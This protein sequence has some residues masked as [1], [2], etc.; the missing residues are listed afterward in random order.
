MTP[1]EPVPRSVLPSSMDHAR[2]RR[3]PAGTA[4]PL[5]RSLGITGRGWLLVLGFQLVWVGAAAVS[6]AARRLTDRVDAAVMRS[7][8]SLRTNWLTEI[9]E[10]IDQ[11]G[12]GWLVT[13]VGLGLLVAL[14]VFR[15]WRH[16]FTFLICVVLVELV[17]GDVIYHGFQRPRPYDV[18]I[19]GR[20][21]GFSLPSPP[22]VVV[23]TLA[24]GI[25]YTLVV[26]GR[27]RTIAKVIAGVVV[28]SFAASRVYLGVD[29]PFDAVLAVALV[30]AILVNAFRWFTPN[31]SFPVTYKS[32]KTAHLDVGGARGEA[33][34]RAVSEQM[35][36]TV[37]EVKH[38]GLEGS[39]G[40]TPLRLRIAGDPDFSVFGKLYA[41]SH[42]RADRWYKLGRTILY[43]RLEDEGPFQSV[44]RL[45]E[46]EDYTARVL[47][48][49]GIP[50]AESYGVVELTPEREYLLVTEFFE[51][52]DEIGVADVDDGVIDEALGIVRLLWDAGLA[53]RDIKP[54]NVLVRDGRV[55]LIDVFFVQVR[56]SPW[57]Q[58]VDLANMML[59]LAVRTDARRVYERARQ[60]FT[61]DDIAEAFAAVRGI[62]SPTQLRIA[63]KNDPRDLVGEF[64]SLAPPRRR[65]AL[66]RWSVRRVLL[67]VA[68]AAGAIVGVVA[69][70][71][72]FRPAHDI[73]V[74]AEPF[75]ERSNVMILMAQS[76]PSATALPCVASVPAGWELQGIRIDDEGATIW[77]DS[78]V[79]GDRAVAATL[80]EEGACPVSEAIPVASDE[81]GIDRFEQPEQLPPDLVSRRTY[82]FPG[83]CVVY[84]FR[85]RSDTS[86]AL[87]VEVDEALSF[88]PRAELVDEVEERSGLRL[89][90]AGVSCVGS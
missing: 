9:V 41:M 29:H 82:L 61:E 15:R 59:V 63:I 65:I 30:V 28:T 7:V 45:V 51:G 12:S 70:G 16:L 57:R 75:C 76:V 62:A 25:T 54:A 52:A 14:M 88:L 37:L 79:G 56:P 20:W 49:A 68:V 85:F 58:A 86:A 6:P 22:V 77:L 36:L 44:R 72:L 23:A 13:V 4:P 50:T 43:G 5:P 83:G 53:H 71:Q 55:I 64:R 38:V 8:V 17:G 3:R 33:I 24:V 74:H 40:S 69:I 34:T 10:E 32:G 42:V 27:S 26:A 1:V 90:G 78:D 84:E 80:R 81:V 31:D 47:H 2:R 11:I 21:A 35:G 66:Q 67:A 89:C 87:T 73:G 19:I 48:D 18:T 39:G 46:Y 60:F